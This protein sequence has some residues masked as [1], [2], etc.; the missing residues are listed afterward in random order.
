MTSQEKKGYLK[1]INFLTI[2]YQKFR[3]QSFIKIIR[4]SQELFMSEIQYQNNTKW[5]C[6][7]WL[8][9]DL[10]KQW[11]FLGIIPKASQTKFNQIWITRSKDIHVHTPVPK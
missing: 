4:L 5:W 3:W 11:S 10:L 2:I 6:H 9:L 8:E 1:L 7:Q